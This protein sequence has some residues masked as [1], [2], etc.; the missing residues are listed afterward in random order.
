MVIGDVPARGLVIELAQLLRD[1]SDHAAVHSAVVHRVM[2]AISTAVPVKK[3]S[4][5][6]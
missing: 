3:S 2:G 4:S 1:R 6:T 5:Q